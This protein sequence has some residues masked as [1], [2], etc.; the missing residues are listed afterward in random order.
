[1]TNMLCFFVLLISFSS[2]APTSQNRVVGMFNSIGKPTIIPM[3]DDPRE[4]TIEDPLQMTVA[5]SGSEKPTETDHREEG[6]LSPPDSKGAYANR[7]TF[8]V[9]SSEMFHAQ[10]ASLTASG[11]KTLRLL[12]TFSK[13]VP[14]LVVLRE[15]DTSGGADRSL[16]LERSWSILQFLTAAGIEEQRLCIGGDGETL[17]SIFAGPVVEISLYS[18]RIFQ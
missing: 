4:S 5:E 1:M 17:P 13:K 16:S 9:E 2:F 11:R 3:K 7:R 6:S 18:W 10:G 8:H 15:V 14:F 12:A